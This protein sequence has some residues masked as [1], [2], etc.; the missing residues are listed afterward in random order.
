MR[1]KFHR[2]GIAAASVLLCAAV[3]IVAGIPASATQAATPAGWPAVACPQG[4]HVTGVF[5]AQASAPLPDGGTAYFYCINGTEARIPVP[6]A[7]FDLTTATE[8]Q[9]NEYGIPSDAVLFA[10]QAVARTPMGLA[11][12]IAGSASSAPSLTVLP[13][14]AST[15]S[16]SQNW[17]GYEATPATSKHWV[18]VQGSLT[19]P[20]ELT[21]SPSLNCSPT[22]R[23]L[24]S[25]VGLGGTNGG[26]LIQ[27]GTYDLN[28][29]YGA[30]YE[31]INANST[32][33]SGM[34]Q[35]PNVRVRAGDAIFEEVSYQSA[36]ALANFYVQDATS[37]TSQSVQVSLSSPYFDGSH[38][39]WIDERTRS[40]TAYN[41]LLDYGSDHWTG[42]EAEN[43]SGTWIYAGNA[44]GTIADTMVAGDTKDTLSR[45]GTLS[46]S[47]FTD[48]WVNCH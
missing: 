21:P 9:L 37:G 27:T 1:G 28:G 14:Y 39:E 44:T 16:T 36:N 34:V 47:S 11:T 5:Y 35:L 46:T 29:A 41:P 20:S 19:E 48:T 22:N 13:D 17:S 23:T 31:Y 25:W 40:G 8:A 10:R 32:S 12:G 18:A 4:P 7:D 33:D 3:S 26:S 15:S 45:P 2:F 24:A 43:D 38:A 6:P 30:F 42:A